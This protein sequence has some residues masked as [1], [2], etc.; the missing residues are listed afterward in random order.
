MIDQNTQSLLESLA[1]TFEA[2]GSENVSSCEKDQV[3]ILGDE[4]G[5]NPERK[6]REVVLVE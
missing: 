2:S 3:G 6:E 1:S 5:E 4:P